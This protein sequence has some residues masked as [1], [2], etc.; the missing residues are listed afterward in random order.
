[1]ALLSHF[2][3]WGDLCK[4]IVWPVVDTHEMLGEVEK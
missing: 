3:N 2:T 4:S 1:M